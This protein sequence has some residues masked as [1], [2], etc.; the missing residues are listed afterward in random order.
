MQ[1]LLLHSTVLDL[2]IIDR[3]VTT[4]REYR[5]EILRRLR[6]QCLM[7]NNSTLHQQELDTYLMLE[8]MGQTTSAASALQISTPWPNQMKFI[9][10]F[11]LDSSNQPF[12]RSGHRAVA[13]ESDLW[14]YGGYN[15]SVNGHPQIFNE[16]RDDIS[17]SNSSD[18]LVLLRSCGDSILLSAAGH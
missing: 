17:S 7:S 16:V 11:P 12:A 15:P 4:D 14:V 5:H 2:I 6:L 1:L 13:T 8:A 9:E 18:L 3:F 10:V